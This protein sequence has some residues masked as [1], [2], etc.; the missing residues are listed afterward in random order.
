MNRA[1]FLAALERGL[2][3]LPAPRRAE[4][5]ADY[6]SYFTEGV[7]A[8]RTEQEVAASLGSPARLSAELR[9]GYEAPRSPLRSFMTLLA[10]VM[11]DGAA[12]A[13]LLAGVFLVLALIGVGVV[14]LVYAGFTLL[15]LPFD[16]PLGG[17]AA[18][19][20]RGVAL[21]TA[22]VAALAAARAGVLLLVR[23]FVR[24]HRRNQRVLRPITE[25][26]P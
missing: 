16:Q 23:F 13:P 20:L 10:L 24:M 14:T 9:L 18:V 1:E 11:L 25:D 2:H 12:W 7:A 21:L 26:S 19:L 4:I 5:V 15:V 22:G 6:Q 3:R 17:F 8:G